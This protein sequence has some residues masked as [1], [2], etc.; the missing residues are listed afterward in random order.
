MNRN[1]V[2][3]AEIWVLSRGASFLL[4]MLLLRAG[5]M[6]FRFKSFPLSDLQMLLPALAIGILLLVNWSLRGTLGQLVG[7][8]VGL[9]CWILGLWMIPLT[10]WPMADL[11]QWIVYGGLGFLL[12]CLIYT[13]IARAS[14]RLR[15]RL[16]GRDWILRHLRTESYFRRLDAHGHLMGLGLIHN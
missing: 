8:L 11:P 9:G 15:L 7:G 6:Y 14:S 5:W 2:S 12:F 10:S 13:G 4:L 1:L 16:H 3:R